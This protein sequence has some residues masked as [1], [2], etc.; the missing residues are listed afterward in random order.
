MKIRLVLITVTFA[1]TASSLMAVA[2][3][4]EFSADVRPILSDH[5]FACHGPD[6]ADRQA[7]LRL[8]T[9]DG[10]ANVVEAGDVDAS[11]L[12]RRLESTDPEDQMPPPEFHKPLSAKQKSI[13]KLWVQ[14][15]AKFQ[16]H[17][18]FATPDLS[19]NVA[20]ESIDDFIDERA[21]AAGLTLNG[22]ADRRS[23]LRRVCLDLTGLPPTRQQ[24]ERFAAD[25]SAEAYERLVDGL[26]QS[27]R[28]GEHMGRFWLD[29]VRYGDTH[30]LHLDN[31][32]EMWQYR[33]WVIAA[34]NQNM[35]MNQFITEQL[36]G[37]LLPNATR[38]QLIASGFNRLKRDDQRRRFDLR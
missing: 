5:C 35:P 22:L 4:P 37:D 8:D 32:R 23:L 10:L 26:L 17:W 7:D 1:T 6:E 13:L 16:Q 19:R 9:A 30:G 24:V 14:G 11:E 27:P 31:Y 36:A 2:E 29:L 18:A 25:K 38:D 21:R 15:G 20:G 12:I 33:D 34:F 28:Y 3:S